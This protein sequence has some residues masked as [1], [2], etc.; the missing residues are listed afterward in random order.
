M[1]QA[2]A[3]VGVSGRVCC[4]GGRHQPSGGGGG[5]SS[6]AQRRGITCR[7]ARQASVQGRARY[8][9]ARPSN[10]R[11]IFAD[12]RLVYFLTETTAVPGTD[13]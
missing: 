11:P 5:E 10:T 4:P 7:R 8:Y 3:G 6:T 13:C 2:A 9:L 1:L 12:E